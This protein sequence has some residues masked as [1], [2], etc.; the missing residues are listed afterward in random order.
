MSY[1]GVN[2]DYQHITIVGGIIKKPIQN[3]N[4]W[5]IYRLRSTQENASSKRTLYFNVLV[6]P[7]LQKKLN[8]TSFSQVKISGVLCPPSN[9]E[10]LP[11]L[12]DIVAET[13]ENLSV[14]TFKNKNFSTSFDYTTIKNKNSY[15]KFTLNKTSYKEQISN[16]KDDEVFDK[17][18]TENN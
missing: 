4:G 3:S 14:E 11:T 12:A 8:T 17:K 7:E 10:D 2:N 5:F 13:F 16:L 18:F 1:L 9:F 6:N 15:N